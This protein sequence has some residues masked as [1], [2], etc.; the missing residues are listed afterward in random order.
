MG[1]VG[2]VGSMRLVAR[3]RIDMHSMAATA[4]KDHH[5]KPA[6]PGFRM[7]RTP[8]KPAKAASQRC[9]PTRSAKSQAAATVVT[10]GMNCRMAEAL[11]MGMHWSAALNIMPAPTSPAMRTPKAAR[12]HAGMAPADALGDRDQRQDQA[13]KSA[14]SHD[15]FAEADLGNCNAQTGIGR[16]HGRAGADHGEDAELGVARTDSG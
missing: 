2:V 5:V 11:A 13:C 1:S 10:S 9:Q 6:V 8:T 12:P 3:S 16:H 4:H 14:A 15:G 7:R